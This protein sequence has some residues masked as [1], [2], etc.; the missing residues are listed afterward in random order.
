MNL[1]V[2][3][4]LLLVFIAQMFLFLVGGSAGETNSWLATG[5]FGLCFFVIPITYFLVLFKANVLEARSRFGR[6]AAAAGWSYLLS[7]GG[8][9]LAIFVAVGIGRLLL[10]N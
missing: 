1:K 2:Y 9:V 5:C 4:R 3:L 8:L 7:I 10:E 6:F